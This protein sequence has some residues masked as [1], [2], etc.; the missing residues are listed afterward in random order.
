VAVG[1]ATTGPGKFGNAAY[2]GPAGTSYVNIT[3]PSSALNSSK[4]LTVSGWFKRTATFANQKI[5]NRYN[6]WNLFNDYGGSGLLYFYLNLCNCTSYSPNTWTF[7]SS[8]NKYMAYNTWYHFTVTYDG[9]LLKLY[10]NG[11]LDS[12]TTKSGTIRAETGP[13]YIGYYNGDAWGTGYYS[14]SLDEFAIWNRTLSAAEVRQ[15][16]RRGANQIRYQ[17]R[18]CA[19]NDCSD[20]SSTTNLGWKGP[21]NTAGSYF[22]EL[23]NTTSNVLGGAALTG[24]PTMNFSNFGSLSL[25]TNRYFQY[26]AILESDDANDSCTYGSSVIPCS[27][28]LQSV[29]IGPDHYNASSPTISNNSGE[30]FDTLSSFAQTLGANGCA[31]GV[32]YNVSR[33]NSTW[34]WWNAGSNAGSGAWATANGTTAQSNAATVMSSNAASFATQVGTGTVY[35]KA[36]LNSTGSAACELDNVQAAGTQ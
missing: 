20:Q 34:Y 1:G 32:T 3:N 28:E 15:L 2:L 19:S 23:Y 29:S 13:L 18:T 12:Q 21:D 35:F 17:V 22:S 9:A 16:Y 25:S 8:K 31:S 7:V 11:V 6:Q 36:F 27:P 14:G 30:A 10:V 5:A 24:L 4:N 26:R 33:D